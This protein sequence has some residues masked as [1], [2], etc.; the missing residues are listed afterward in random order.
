MSF[1]TRLLVLAASLCAVLALAGTAAATPAR[2]AGPTNAARTADITD[3]DQ[4]VNFVSGA[5]NT[6]WNW[7]F[8]ARLHR[9]YARPAGIYWYTTTTTSGCGATLPGNAFYCAN[10]HT[11]WLDKNLIAY[12]LQT[13]REDFAGAAVIAHEWG[14]WVQDQLGWLQYARNN[15]YWVGKELQADCYAGMFTRYLDGY[16]FLEPGD[17]EEGG[18]LMVRIGDEPGV[19]RD[20]ERAHGTPAERLGWFMYGYR[21][22]NLYSCNSVYR[23]IY[24]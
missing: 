13:V 23:T 7:W 6:Y 11:V 1:S 3:P 9:T 19:R 20:D 22:G 24:D 4:L 15:R 10:D 16:R 17:L 8:S 21:T 14:H 12:F 18:R 5:L 2:D